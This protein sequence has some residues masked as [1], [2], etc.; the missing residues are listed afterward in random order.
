ML[1]KPFLP[2]L[3]QID[4]GQMAIGVSG[5][6]PQAEK[7]R[8]L[9]NESEMNANEQQRVKVAFAEGYLAGHGQNQPVRAKKW[10]KVVQQIIIFGIFIGVL[11]SFIGVYKC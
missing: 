6:S 11:I 9:L 5:D 10:Y 4:K 1:K 3:F 2:S 8:S 7:L